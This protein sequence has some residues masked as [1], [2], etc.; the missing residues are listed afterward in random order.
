M[1]TD[2]MAKKVLEKMK[3]QRGYT[4]SELG[5]KGLGNIKKNSS[6]GLPRT[7]Q[8]TALAIGRHLNTFEEQNLI[9]KRHDDR[10]NKS[11]WYKTIEGESQYPFI[12]NSKD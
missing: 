5:Y 12:E 7:S 4:A 10:D 11:Y 2:S 6:F 9:I 8:G 1:S 3:L